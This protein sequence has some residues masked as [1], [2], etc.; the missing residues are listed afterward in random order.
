[1]KKIAF[2]VQRYGLEVNG[3][4]E[5]HCRVLAE[6]LKDIYDI[7][8]LT[9]SAMDYITWSN[10][11]PEGISFINDIKVRR[12]NTLQERNKGE[13]SLVERTLNKRR[14]HQKFF[15]FFGLLSRFESFFKLNTNV[16][17]LSYEWSKH[18][19]PFVPGLIEYIAE[20]EQRFDVFIFFTYLYFPTFYGIK[21]APH[22]SILIPTAHDEPAIYLP[23]FKS[24][25]K[26]PK[27]ILYNTKAEKKLINRLFRNS[28][29]YDDIVGIGIDI[30][31]PKNSSDA[32]PL[33]PDP[34]I[35]YIG[36]I[37]QSKGCGILIEYFLRYKE[38][39]QNELKLVLIGHA[40]MEI[41][42]HKDILKMGFVDDNLKALALLNSKALVI[43]SFFE[44]LSLVTL[45]SMAAGVPV[46]ANEA[47]QVLKDHILE[48]KSGFL[49]SG[50]K[51]FEVALETIVNGHEDLGT[52]QDNGRNYVKE[53]YDWNIVISKINKAIDYVIFRQ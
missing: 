12:F 46:I 17:K 33:S 36:R 22:K 49:F 2:I 47:C 52:M 1:M 51:S 35:V 53:R 6:R 18:Q 19:G 16:E 42:V 23:A 8:V 37:D 32:Q 9:S 41:P 7:E 45:E 4:A 11:Y 21:V 29:I 14:W 24:L 30:Q 25:F 44:S 40:F 27:A 5:F 48:S 34:Y 15:K 13:F 10:A 31:D 39:F 38:T 26:L 28:K 43:P 20:N 50:Y 3:G